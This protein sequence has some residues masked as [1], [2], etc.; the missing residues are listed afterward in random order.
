MAEP[1]QSL[2]QDQQNILE[3]EREFHDEWAKAIDPAKVMVRETFTASTSPESA[4][5]FKRLG[6]LRDLK[7]LDLGSGAGESAV[8]FALH[9]AKVT[10]TDLSG[11]MCAVV[12]K[13]AAHYGTE[14]DST[15]CNAEDL[16]QFADASFDIVFAANVL[17]HVDLHKC[18][19]EIRRVL[20]PGGRI[21]SWD[22]VAHNPI[23]NIYRGMAMEV[24]TEDEHPI[25]MQD[26]K[27]FNTYF[28]SIDKKF[29][30]LSS[31][32]LFLKFYVIDRVHPNEDRYWK[33]IL[34]HEK[35]NAWFYKPLA[36]LDEILLKIP[37]LQWWAWNIAIIGRRRA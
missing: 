13:V 20:K 14:L 16:S 22:P 28:D 1:A 7:L 23:I 26:M 31:L 33:R 3:R 8:W 2:T 17:H 6:D 18:M 37:M 34:T 12:K 5:L 30:W 36:A 24:R 35:E 21:A 4:W 19:A 25:R 11:E 27:V 9:G 10:A 15:V 29:F 32:V